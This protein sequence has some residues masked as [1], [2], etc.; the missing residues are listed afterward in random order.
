MKK[1]QTILAAAAL[2]FA[3]SAFAAKGPEKISAAVKKAFEKQFSTAE[4]VSWE[5]ADNFYFVNF[6]MKDRDMS[7][8]YDENGEMVGSSRI[9]TIDELPTCVSLAISE[10]YNDYE[11][12]KLGSEIHFE[13]QD[14]YYVT[15]E[16]SKHV[17]KLKC[18]SN[19]D[20]SVVTK[21]KK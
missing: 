16:N 19:G 18:L 15:V 1:F 7:V 21:T 10:K 9:I 4:K 6:K 17:L 5:R 2:L 11:V 12:G 3:T 13:G 20:I 8:A 14:S